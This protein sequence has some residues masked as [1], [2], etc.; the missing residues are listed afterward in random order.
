MGGIIRLGRGNQSIGLLPI[1]GNFS[2]G[3][4]A[5]A[6]PVIDFS[7]GE[8]KVVYYICISHFLVGIRRREIQV[9]VK[10]IIY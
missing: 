3:I 8:S 7:M 6:S 9:I 10:K 5:P 1:D 4:I 2:L